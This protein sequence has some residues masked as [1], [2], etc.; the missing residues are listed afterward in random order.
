M[1]LDAA[2]YVEAKKFQEKKVAFITGITGQVCRPIIYCIDCTRQQ[3]KFTT[4]QIKIKLFVSI[5][6]IKIQN[7]G[8]V[9][10]P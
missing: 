2:D 3:M 7:V 9:T 5:E 8:S 10:V 1:S 4:I 6:L